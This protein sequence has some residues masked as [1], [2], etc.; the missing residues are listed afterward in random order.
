MKGL[1]CFYDTRASLSGMPI[2]FDNDALARESMIGAL[3]SNQV[4]SF[5]IDDVAV[6]R[7]G[8]YDDSDGI[9][10][11]TGVTPTV[12]MR[13]TDKYVQER[14]EELRKAFDEASC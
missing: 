11:I 14:I 7:I 5:V 8:D 6:Y 12:I 13:G 4:P 3:C 1:Y 9:P 2:A 10:L